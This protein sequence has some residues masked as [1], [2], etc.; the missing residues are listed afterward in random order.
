MISNR[1]KGKE[2][3]PPK[4]KRCAYCK[5]YFQ[6]TPFNPLQS[7][8][9]PPKPCSWKRAE[10]LRLK[11]EQQ[12]W[13]VEKQSIKE[14]HKSITWFINDARVVFQKWVR[15]RDANDG[16]ISCGNKT[17]TQYDAGHYF[18]AETITGLIFHPDNCHKQCSRPCNKDLAGDLI[19]YRI[20]L[21]KKIGE[22]RVH[23]ME[24][25]IAT[26][27]KYKFTKDELIEIKQFYQS[28]IDALN[29]AK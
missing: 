13:K 28:K 4:K 2:N 14:K 19:N 7:V 10:Q 23:W 12:E 3:K 11:K 6:P 9:F 5:E 22:Q 1:I 21:V 29:N 25:N 18:K 24:N 17:A 8:C 27:R 15:L 20:A 26:L 16:C